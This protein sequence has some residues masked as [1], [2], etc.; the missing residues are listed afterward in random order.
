MH[1]LPASLPGALP[2]SL[3]TLLLLAPAAHGWLGI[4]FDASREEAVVHEAIAGSPA[5]KAGLKPGDVLIAVGDKKTPKREDFIAAIQATKVGDEVAIKV[6]RGD[7]ELSVSVRLAEKPDNV[8]PPLT[9]PPAA[10]PKA[11]RAPAPAPATETPGPTPPAKGATSG[12][13]LGIAVNEDGGKVVVERVLD[14]SPAAAADLRAGDVITSV[15]GQKVTDLD[16]LDA[17]MQ[18]ARPGSKLE[19]QLQ[20]EQGARSVTITV[21]ERPG[22]KAATQRKA[23]R[24]VPAPAQA[25][26][27]GSRSEAD[28]EAELEALRAELAEVRRLL[29]ELR[30]GKE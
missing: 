28:V 29:E 4:Y 8:P 16:Q 25:P 10:K 9:E 18:K 24:V 22:P 14:G 20:G 21:G 23:V 5:D 12:G 19:V 30:K 26:R 17:A 13:Y 1:S 11:G 7:E 6:R 3:L 15:G 27:P 2:A